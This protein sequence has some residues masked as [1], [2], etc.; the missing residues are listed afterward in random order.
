[1]IDVNR[2]QE[3]VGDSLFRDEELAGGQPEHVVEGDGI[4]RKFGFHPERLEGHREDVR[5]M[6]MELSDDFMAT[7]GG[8]MSF[9]N[10]PMDKDGH[11]WGEQVNAGD[12]CALGTA[13]GLVSFPLPREMW[14]VLPG[15]VPYVM[16]K[17]G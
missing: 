14:E 12:L 11:Q 6:L 1:M 4:I 3:I 16:V 17:D 13:L 2:I 9:L 10:M 7:K 15:N 8:G 5:G